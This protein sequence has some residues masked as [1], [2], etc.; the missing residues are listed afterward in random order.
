MNRFQEKNSKK[1]KKCEV[2]EEEG[3]EKW[4]SNMT[5]VLGGN[6]KKIIEGRS[7]KCKK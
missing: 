4:P 5:D 7:K 3:T 2:P 6:I 1:K